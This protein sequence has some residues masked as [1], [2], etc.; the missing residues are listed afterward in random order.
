MN[1]DVNVPSIKK[2][3]EN[4]GSLKKRAG[5]GA[6]SGS[7]NQKDAIALTVPGIVVHTTPDRFHQLLLGFQSLLLL[8][9]CQR[10]FLV[11]LGFWHFGLLYR[12]LSENRVVNSRDVIHI[13]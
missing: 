13:T 5:S 3:Q 1:I 12:L 7:I 6:G 10:N 11:P 2:K 8:H 9:F 4:K